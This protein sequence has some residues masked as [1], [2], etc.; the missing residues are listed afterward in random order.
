MSTA[1]DFR[2]KHLLRDLLDFI[3]PPLCQ[4]CRK[5]FERGEDNNIWLCPHC[6][7]TL[8]ILPHPHCAI[9]R[10][11][12]PDPEAH[13]ANCRKPS[14]LLW[15]YSLG[16]YDDHCSHLIKAFKYESRPELGKM[17]GQLLGM[18]L[19]TFPHAR[20]IDAICAIPID[21]RKEAQRGF[22]QTEVLAEQVARVLGLPYQSD[23][24]LLTRRNRDQIG[25]S[26]E[27][28]YQ[29]VRGIFKLADAA[30]FKGKNVLLVDDVTTS[31][32]T[33]NSAAVALLSA[34]AGSVAAATVAMALEDGLEP[35]TL[36][37]LMSDEF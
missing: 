25:L 31:G 17:L 16:I 4:V 10:S 18:Q 36:Y 27:Q 12:L 3:Y 23:R 2:A 13:C 32:A 1:H 21:P 19:E 9:C 14:P 15:V 35:H 34:G 11:F 26:V 20:K 22:N 7:A 30:E 8:N 6:R 24:L 33:L 5:S 37:A 28:R 29:N